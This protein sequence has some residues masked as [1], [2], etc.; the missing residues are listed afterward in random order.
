MAKERLR[1]FEGPTEMGDLK[2]TVWDRDGEPWFN[3]KEVCAALGMN[4]SA[5]TTQWTKGLDGTERLKVTRKEL[6]EIFSGSRAPSYV[7][8][9]ESGLYKLIMRSNKPEAAKFQDW[10]TK[11]VLPAIRKDGGEIAKEN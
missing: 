2:F 9:S 4:L 6:P 1:T 7:M 8:I 10:V 5:G 11:V 3:A